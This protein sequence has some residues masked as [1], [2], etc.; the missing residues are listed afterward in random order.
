MYRKQ[1]SR[2][3]EFVDFV[4]PFGGWLSA[5]NR[6]VKKAELIPW[7]ELEPLYEATLSGSDRGAPA[8]SFRIALGS[9]IIKETLQLSDEETVEQIYENP[10]LQYF[11]GYTSFLTEKPFDASMM[12]HFRKRLKWNDLQTINERIAGIKRQSVSSEEEEKTKGP[13]SAAGCGG[14]SSEADMAPNAGVLKIDATCTPAD[15][16]YPTD[17]SLVEEARRKSEEIIDRL[18]AATANRGKKPRTYRRKARKQFL[19]VMRKRVR[20]EKMIRKA[21]GAQLRF[22]CRNLRSIQKL[23]TPQTLSALTK[24]QYKALLVIQEVYRQ[25]GEM[26]RQKTH[27]I[28]GRIVSIRQPHIRPIVRGKAGAE[29]EFGA[30]VS[31][32]PGRG[33]C[34]CGPGCV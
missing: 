19:A 33:V 10:Y 6:W 15:I 18:Y 12:V 22:L 26:Y 5:T 2:Q 9:Q 7:E 20:N 31:L 17:L 24:H 23:A 28:E 14:G 1:D 25:Q 29:V 8:L 21:L 11:L 16:R 3:Q 34:A 30:K 4:L 13:G 27:R 32:Q